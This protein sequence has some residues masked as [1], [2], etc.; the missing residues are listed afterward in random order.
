MIVLRARDWDQCMAM[1]RSCGS[2]AFPGLRAILRALNHEQGA[3]MDAARAIAAVGAIARLR[4]IIERHRDNPENGL[5]LLE[6]SGVAVAVAV[7]AM[8]EE[9]FGVFYAAA[10]ASEAVGT[11][12]HTRGAIRVWR[13]SCAARLPNAPVRVQDGYVGIRPLCP[14]TARGDDAHASR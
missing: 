9:P 6:F 13:A 2:A 11:D 4:L 10:A 3:L 8:R 14:C 5:E 12:V 1:R 7:W